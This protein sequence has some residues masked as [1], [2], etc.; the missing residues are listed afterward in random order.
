MSQAKRGGW[1][2]S[3]NASKKQWTDNASRFRRILA[4]D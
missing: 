1:L 3:S 4:S 2:R